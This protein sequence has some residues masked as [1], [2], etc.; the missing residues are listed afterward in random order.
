MR[1]GKMKLR[2]G[3]RL[4]VSASYYVSWKSVDCALLQITSKSET[5]SRT[6]CVKML[7]L[8]C[9]RCCSDVFV[10]VGTSG[11]YR[12]CRLPISFLYLWVFQLR[13]LCHA[14]DR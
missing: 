10:S 9:R 7:R 6:T 14:T 5:L 8:M 4:P 11:L 2:V 13:C 3:I 1:K 12:Q